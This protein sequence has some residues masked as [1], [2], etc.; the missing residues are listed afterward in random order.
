MN[1]PLHNEELKFLLRFLRQE[2]CT[3]PTVWRLQN[4]AL[5]TFSTPTFFFL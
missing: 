4:Q 5:N 2:T 3:S 1:L